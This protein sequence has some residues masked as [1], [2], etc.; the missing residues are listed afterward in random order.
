VSK[1]QPFTITDLDELLDAMRNLPLKDQKTVAEDVLR[2]LHE[3]HWEI[4]MD[5]DGSL[6]VTKTEEL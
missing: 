2:R 5:Y 6:T 1:Y 4:F 3:N